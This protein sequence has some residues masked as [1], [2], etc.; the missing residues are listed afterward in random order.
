MKMNRRTPRHVERDWHVPD[1][2]RCGGC[3]VEDLDFLKRS[4]KV[5]HL[6]F[7][8]PPPDQVLT[9]AVDEYETGCEL[10]VFDVPRRRRKAA[11]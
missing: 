9:L 1:R 2:R 8:S 6:A 11:A 3:R 10:T 7:T 5:F 4:T